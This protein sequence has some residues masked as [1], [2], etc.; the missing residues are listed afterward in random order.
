MQLPCRVYWRRTF[1]KFMEIQNIE[2]FFYYAASTA[3]VRD[4]GARI[5]PVIE[6]E[7]ILRL[8]APVPE[9]RRCG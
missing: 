5:D 1:R 7:A 4:A 9:G 3:Q 6:P 8:I 2:S